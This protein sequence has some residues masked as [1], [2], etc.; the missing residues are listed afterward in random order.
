[1]EES[2]SVVAEQ[3]SGKILVDALGTEDVQSLVS[4]LSSAGIEQIDRA[5]LLGS[6][7][8]GILSD[9]KE[10][11]IHFGPDGTIGSIRDLESGTIW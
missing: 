5:A 3:D 2:G 11:E 10:Y 9:G 7:T 1:M 4:G 6:G 8:L